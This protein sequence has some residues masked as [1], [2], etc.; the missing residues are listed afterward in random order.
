MNATVQPP[1]P[2]TLAIAIPQ[3]GVWEMMRPDLFG[4]S[5]PFWGFGQPA[6]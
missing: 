1:T 4:L 2:A 3:R 5:V 6:V